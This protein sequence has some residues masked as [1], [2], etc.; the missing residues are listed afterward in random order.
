MLSETLYNKMMLDKEFMSSMNKVSI[1]M[2]GY[3]G[4]DESEKE[5]QGARLN[6]AYNDY[7][8]A[9]FEVSLLFSP[10]A[11]RVPSVI[12]DFLLTV[13]SIAKIGKHYLGNLNEIISNS[14]LSKSGVKRLDKVMSN[15]N[16]MLIQLDNLDAEVS[17]SIDVYINT[18]KPPERQKISAYSKSLL[19]IRRSYFR[20]HN[21]LG[22]LEKHLNFSS[23]TYKPYE[24]LVMML[25]SQQG[26]RARKGSFS[27]A[28]NYSEYMGMLSGNAAK[29]VEQVYNFEAIVR[30]R[31]KRK[32]NMDIANTAFI[33]NCKLPRE[34]A[35]KHANALRSLHPSIIYG[36]D[37]TIAQKLQKPN[38]QPAQGR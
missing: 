4:C 25:R 16:Q 22:A 18:G 19:R 37:T 10:R 5:H 3:A 32:E 38:A 2:S 35:L 14:N 33:V 20:V 9:A 29:Y 26:P 6:S 11:S 13:A 8:K 12:G 36:E 28:R 23:C 15:I 31:G 24:P 34:V 7:H 21:K 27:S 30:S 17:S 1:A